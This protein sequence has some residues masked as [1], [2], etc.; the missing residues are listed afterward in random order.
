ML[1]LRQEREENPDSSESQ[2]DETTLYIAATSGAKKRKLYG[3]AL[4][5]YFLRLAILKINLKTDNCF[6]KTFASTI[7]NLKL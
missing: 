7:R 1:R 3:A 2:V 4:Q 5:C 6:D